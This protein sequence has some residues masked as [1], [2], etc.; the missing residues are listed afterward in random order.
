MLAVPREVWSLVPE[1]LIRTR[2]VFA[3]A[4][5]G[6]PPNGI[7]VVAMADPSDLELIDEV[8]FATGLRIRAVAA[9]PATLRRLVALHLGGAPLEVPARAGASAE[10]PEAIT[11][12]LPEERGRALRA[13]DW[14]VPLAP[15]DTKW[16]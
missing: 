4:R 11:L 8:R 10:A 2:A 3:M 12:D 9:S 15:G 6:R 14:I 5:E 13:E 1:R 7:L 16:R